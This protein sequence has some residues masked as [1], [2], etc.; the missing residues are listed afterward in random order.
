MN[1][2]WTYLQ[3]IDFE[4]QVLVLDQAVDSVGE[5]RFEVRLPRTTTSVGGHHP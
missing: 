5:D 4:V 2:D 1:Q 3:R